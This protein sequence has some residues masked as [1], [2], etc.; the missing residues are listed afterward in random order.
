M[1]QVMFGNNPLAEVIEFGE[2][3]A[4]RGRELAGIPHI[5]ER[6]FVRWPVPHFLFAFDLC[7]KRLGAQRPFIANAV[8]YVIA[9]VS[10]EHA[11]MPFPFAHFFFKAP[12]LALPHRIEI[13]RND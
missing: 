10:I 2:I 9:P 7:V 4:M 12:K 3:L 1:R 13:H 6:Q 8:F 11:A 5:V